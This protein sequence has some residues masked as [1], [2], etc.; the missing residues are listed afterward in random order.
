MFT[1]FITVALLAAN[2]IQGVVAFGMVTPEL[3][4]CK[5]AHITW[6]QTKAPYNLVVVPSNNTCG[7]I[8]ADLGDH[9]GTSMTWKVTLRAGNEV[10]LS[11]E[12]AYGD[13]A[14]SGSITIGASTDNSCLSSA[15]PKSSTTSHSTSTATTTTPLANAAATPTS[16]SKSS[17]SGNTTSSSS[18][19]SSGALNVRQSSGP[20]LAM[21]VFIGAMTLLL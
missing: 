20:V 12:D 18:T 5:D 19:V 10:T 1:T 21:S 17:S 6:N 13:E 8:L 4:Q 2:I 7:D 11:V 16:T 15:D 3:T 14:W 9:N